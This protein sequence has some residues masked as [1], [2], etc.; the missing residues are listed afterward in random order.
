M[1]DFYSVNE[2]K[3]P[4]GKRVYHNSECGP[5]REIPQSDRRS[6]RNGYRFCDDCQ[7]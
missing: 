2:A 5:A 7:K 4:E 3:K 1:A 6:G